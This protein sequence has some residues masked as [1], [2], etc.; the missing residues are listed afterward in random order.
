MVLLSLFHASCSQ[1]P[2]SG[3]GSAYAC[4]TLRIFNFSYLSLWLFISVYCVFIVWSRCEQLQAGDTSEGFKAMAASVEAKE[5][6]ALKKSMQYTGLFGVGP[7]ITASQPL[8]YGS[9]ASPVVGGGAEIFGRHH[10]TEYP[11]AA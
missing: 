6:A 1:L 9:L 10:E 4:G 2:G 3:A 8:V 5:Q 11:P 7:A